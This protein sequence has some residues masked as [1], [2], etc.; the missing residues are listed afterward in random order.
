MVKLK[1]FS[2]YDPL[3]RILNDENDFTLVTLPRDDRRAETN[4]RDGQGS[5]KGKVL[6]AYNNKCCISGE[7]IEELLEASHI[8]PYRNRD[9]NHVQNGLLL[10]V[11]IHRLYD[12]ELIFIDENYVVHVSDLIT[13][14]QYRQYDGRTIILPK[15]INEHPSK[16]ALGIRKTAFRNRI[17]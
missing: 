1:Y 7:D 6:K 17:I 8:Q 2:E 10:R 9:S 13:S 12:N 5:F 14:N 4:V 11:D 15:S 3:V 16:A